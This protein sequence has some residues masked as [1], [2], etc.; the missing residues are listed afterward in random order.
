MV[1]FL[2]LLLVGLGLFIGYLDNKRNSKRKMK[3]LQKILINHKIA[4]DAINTLNEETN[5]DINEY[6]K[7]VD[8]LTDNSLDI[9]LLALGSKYV[10]TAD[11]LMRHDNDSINHELKK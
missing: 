3:I 4:L 8:K 7:T 2:I 11:W 5:M 6:A 10:D 1:I 9:I